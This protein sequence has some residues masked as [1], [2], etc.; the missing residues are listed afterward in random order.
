[1]TVKC[2][3]INCLYWSVSYTVFLFCHKIQWRSYWLVRIV[4]RKHHW[5]IFLCKC[6][7]GSHYAH[8]S[9]IHYF[10]V[11]A[12]HGI[13]ANDVWFQQ[14]GATCHI[15]LDTI[16]FLRQTFGGRLFNRNGNA[17]WPP[18]SCDWKP[19]DYLTICSPTARAFFEATT[20]R[21]AS[22]FVNI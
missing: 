15:P 11:P 20:E 9:M 14:D 10:F 12:L 18:I 21:S 22:K 1:M 5:P 8:W 6:A 3:S 2:F 16:D 4:E 17:H 7:R 13:A 19:L